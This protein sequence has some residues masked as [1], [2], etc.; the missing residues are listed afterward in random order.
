MHY[1]FNSWVN[2]PCATSISQRCG[3]Y[4]EIQFSFP[5]R[6]VKWGP[7]QQFGFKWVD[8]GWHRTI[9]KLTFWA[10][11][12]YLLLISPT[13]AKGK[14]SNPSALES[15]FDT[16]CALSHRCGT[17][18]Y[19]MANEWYPFLL[20]VYLCPTSL[21]IRRSTD[22][23]INLIPPHSFIHYISC[24]VN[25]HILFVIYFIY[26][27]VII[28]FLSLFFFSCLL[29]RLIAWLLIWGS[30]SWSLIMTRMC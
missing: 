23:L 9:E 8:K 14:R 27:F 21:R 18:I 30:N 29:Y 24:P 12:S 26:L 10:F 28:I 5:S 20:L 7:T 4:N 6:F 17:I 1:P 3:F 22:L 25:G 19:A 16:K 13:D 11:C 2:F 15:S